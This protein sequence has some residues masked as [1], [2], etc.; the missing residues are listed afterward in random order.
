MAKSSLLGIDADNLSPLHS[1]KGNDSLGP[2]DASDSGSDS[3]GLY[4][5]DPDNDTDR[6]GTGERASVEPELQ[7]ESRDILPDHLE[8]MDTDDDTAE[9]GD[10]RAGADRYPD[11]DPAD[12]PE[13]DP[14]AGDGAE[15]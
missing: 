5:T 2:S 3:T 8:S 9:N 7:L 12:D 13:L 4:G 6:Y 1:A 10:V 15:A 14:D 11:D